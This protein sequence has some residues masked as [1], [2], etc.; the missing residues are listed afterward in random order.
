[1]TSSLSLAKHTGW[2]DHIENF[3]GHPLIQ[4]GL[5]VL[6]ILNA[7]I[8]GLETSNDWMR[9][10]GEELHW[11]DHAILAVFMAEIVL[12][13]AARGWTYFKD[14]WCVF[15]FIVVGIALIP[16][17]SRS[18]LVAVSSGVSFPSRSPPSGN[19]RLNR[20]WNTRRTRVLWQR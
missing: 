19:Q 8:L 17:S 20:L 18:S 13:I 12:L 11:I 15:D 5:V 14:P 2:R 16:A 10:W 7:A 6:I 3:M 1:M 4:N 9:G